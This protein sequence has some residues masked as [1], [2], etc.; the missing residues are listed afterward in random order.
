[1]K[2]LAKKG[3]LGL[4]VVMFLSVTLIGCSNGLSKEKLERLVAESIEETIT[5][6]DQYGA[7]KSRSGTTNLYEKFEVKKVILI[8]KSQ[9]EYTGS[10]TI[11]CTFFGGSPTESYTESLTVFADKDSFQWEFK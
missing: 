11:N 7:S 3:L 4:I 9:N 5:N 1:M 2:N 10:A 8:K 6:N